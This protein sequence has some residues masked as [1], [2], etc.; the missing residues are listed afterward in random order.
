MTAKTCA[1]PSWQTIL[2]DTANVLDKI[3]TSAESTPGSNDLS[4][5]KSITDKTNLSRKIGRL[6]YLWLCCD[7]YSWDRVRKV[8]W[9]TSLGMRKIQRLWVSWR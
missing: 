4:K 3:R 1:I 6:R 2:H 9:Q 5:H 7:V 8:S